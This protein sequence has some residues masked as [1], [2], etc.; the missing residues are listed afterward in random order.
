MLSVRSSV[1]RSTSYRRHESHSGRCL[2][3]T[4]T[5]VHVIQLLIKTNSGLDSVSSP[6]VHRAEFNS[7]SYSFKFANFALHGVH[8][9]LSKSHGR[10]NRYTPN[11]Y[12][13]HA[14][15]LGTSPRHNN[16][17]VNWMWFADTCS[18]LDT[19][20]EVRTSANHAASL[21]LSQPMITD[22]ALQV[23]QLGGRAKRSTT[24]GDNWPQIDR[25]NRTLTLKRM[26][27]PRSW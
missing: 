25:I 18:S 27:I 6:T 10:S 2:S 23:L 14:I 3:Y 26:H 21:L 13:I 24:T 7:F 15:Q 17:A 4:G 12:M 22:T 19:R 8:E 11:K 5:F 20:C 9:N 1:E 16:T